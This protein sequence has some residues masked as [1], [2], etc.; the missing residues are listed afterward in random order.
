MLFRSS[1]QLV[2]EKLQ[3]AEDKEQLAKEKL[4]TAEDKE[5]LATEKLSTAEDKEQLANEKLQTAE[6]KEQWT[7]S[8]VGGTGRGGTGVA[9]TAAA[10]A[11]INVAQI[12]ASAKMII[13]DIKNLSDGTADLSEWMSLFVN[14]LMMA[15][16]VLQLFGA[17]KLI[18]G[19]LGGGEIG[20]ASCRER[21]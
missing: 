14:G 16:D 10:L 11:L 1:E 19:A 2:D 13:D 17:F 3:T 5:Q 12:G 20:R 18:K 4:S 9:G 21:V 7:L 8:K 15:V 6:D